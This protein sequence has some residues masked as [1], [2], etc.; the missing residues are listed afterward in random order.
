MPKVGDVV[1]FIPGEQWERYT[2]PEPLLDGNDKPVM[3]NAGNPVVRD[4]PKERLL[5]RPESPATVTK[6]HDDDR[7]LDLMVTPAGG[8]PFESKNVPG[9]REATAGQRQW[10][11]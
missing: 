9:R 2:E 1:K 8:A 6:V 7:Y 3:D 11:L 5:P 4:M 10:R